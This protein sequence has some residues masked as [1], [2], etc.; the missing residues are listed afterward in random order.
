MYPT[1]PAIVG[2]YDTDGS[3]G[4]VAISENYV[5]VGDGDAGIVVL[6]VSDPTDPVFAGGYD[7]PGYVG[8]LM[9]VGDLLCV[10][11]DRLVIL[12]VDKAD[13]PRKG[14]LNGDDIT[15]ADVAIALQ[16]AASGAHDDATDIDGNGCVTS[17]DARMIMQAAAGRIE[18]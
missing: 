3:S 13:T 15:P 11:D 7:T 18:L 4:G 14:D 8:R 1:A 16:I 10:A 6:D 2:Q 9:N 5:Y 12:R 17:L